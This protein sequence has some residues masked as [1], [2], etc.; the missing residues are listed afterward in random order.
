MGSEEEE[1]EEEEE[2]GY[3]TEDSLDPDNMTYEVLC[4]ALMCCKAIRR[5]VR[6]SDLR[7]HAVLVRAMQAEGIVPEPQVST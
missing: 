4:C 5:A 1:E 7:F 6:L 2:E 3:F